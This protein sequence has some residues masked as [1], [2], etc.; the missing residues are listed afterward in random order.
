MAARY[1]IPQSGDWAWDGAVWAATATGA[2]G[3]AAT[4]VDGDDVYVLSGTAN[5]TSSLDQSGVQLNSLTIGF[6]GSIGTSGASLLIGLDTSDQAYIYGS[7]TIRIAITQTSG[8][9]LNI[10]DGFSGACYLTGGTMSLIIL[11]RNGSCTISAG[12]YTNI[13]T[14]GCALTIGGSATVS[15]LLTMYSGNHLSLVSLVTVAA[16]GSSTLTLSGYSATMGVISMIG[17]STYI[18]DSGGDITAMSL[19]P[20]T[21]AIATGTYGGFTVTAVNL[22]PGAGLFVDS[23]VPITI[24]T[25]T[26][27]GFR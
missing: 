12:T 8:S 11:G 2:A 10:L 22:W 16:Y 7:G 4:P 9:T 21:R 19:T 15:G 17:S 25:T 13:S 1:F 5:I 6:S 3:S 27:I 24:T 26:K 18:H 20:N 14:A 23:S